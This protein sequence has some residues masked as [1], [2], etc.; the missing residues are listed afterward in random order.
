MHSFYFIQYL[1]ESTKQITPYQI[2]VGIVAL[3]VESTQKLLFIF[4]GAR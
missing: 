1:C 3:F 2:C 4:I